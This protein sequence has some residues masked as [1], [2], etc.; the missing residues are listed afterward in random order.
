[1]NLTIAT[2][3]TNRNT[4]RSVCCAYKAY[5]KFQALSWQKP[6]Y[7]P[8][9]Q[10][11]FIPTEE[12]LQFATNSGL[13]PSIS[14]S[15]FVYETGSRLN[16]AERLEWTDINQEHNQVTVKASKNGKA[17]TIPISKHLIE[18]LLSFPK[19]GNNVFPKRANGSRPVAFR[20]RL[21][22]LAKR[23][24]NPRFRKIHFHSLRHCKALREYDKT[25]S[26]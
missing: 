7:K 26:M 13:R 9:H 12:E 19:N 23:H 18:A 14:F 15:T 20:S 24:N 3:F 10:Q 16:E 11:V 6:N 17:R 5:V 1:M 2:H 4:Q 21:I 22:T 25:H 8:Y